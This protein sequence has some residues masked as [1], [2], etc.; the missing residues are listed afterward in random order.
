MTHFH[1]VAGPDTA[2]DYPIVRKIGPVDLKD[3]LAKGVNDFLAIHD[4]LALPSSLIFLGMIYPIVCIYL[5]TD[6]LPLLFPLM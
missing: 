6:G 5:I 4:V 1:L 3:A 2:P